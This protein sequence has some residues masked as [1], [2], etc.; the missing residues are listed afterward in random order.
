MDAL[1]KFFE[2]YAVVSMSGDAEKLSEY[3]AEHFIIASKDQ[4]SVFNNDTKF[5]DWLK[6]VSKFNQKTGLIKMIVKNVNADEF[7]KDFHKASVTWVAIFSAKPEEEIEFD[8]HYILSETEGKFK[9]VL[10]V[11]DD[12]QEALMKEKDVL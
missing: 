12:D 2:D 8:I 10:Y 5:I 9:I 3:Y 4:S 7:G 1:K 6:E 11:S